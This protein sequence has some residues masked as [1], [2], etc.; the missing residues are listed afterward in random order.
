MKTLIFD[1]DDTLLWDKKS[2]SE[3]LRA[4]AFDAEIRTGVK[5]PLLVETVKQT[6]PELY[7][8]LSVYDFTKTI[9]INAFEGLWGHFD[10]IEHRRFQEMS[11]LISSY[12]KETWTR[13]LSAHGIHQPETGEWL[14]NRFIM[15]RRHLPYVYSDTFEVL[16]TLKDQYQLLML[17]NGSPSLQRLKLSLTPALVPFFDHIIISG[18]FGVGKPDPSIFTHALRLAGSDPENTL[19]IGDNMNTDISGAKN[20]GISS[21]WINHDG[22]IPA[23]DFRADHELASLGEILHILR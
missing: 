2:I 3:A 19:M 8:N 11:R 12:Q 9:G 14:K 16:H 23:H 15:H 22:S 21:A 20:A 18:E 13:A 6:A 10:D 4:T 1:L 17:T 7:K 5:A